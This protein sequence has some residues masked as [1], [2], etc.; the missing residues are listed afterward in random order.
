[1]KFFIENK[2]ID[3]IIKEIK[4]KIYL[5]M[6]GD[7]AESMAQHGL[8]YKKNF[9]VNIPRIREISRDYEPNHDLSARLWAMKIRETMILATLLQPTEKFTK[10]DAESWMKSVSQTELAEQVSMNLFSKLPFAAELSLDLIK[11]HEMWH[12]IVGFM[13]SARISNLFSQEQIEQIIERAVELSDTEELHLY[14]S[15]SLALSR[16]CRLGKEIVD[17]VLGKTDDF[18]DSEMISKKYIYSE[19]KNEVDFM[20]F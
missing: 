10:S 8:V 2:Q 6:N 11:S 9:G 17:K 20:N 1:M 7:V 14:K 18:A 15:I 5:S 19:I 12:Q 13:T 16:F 4:G 3:G